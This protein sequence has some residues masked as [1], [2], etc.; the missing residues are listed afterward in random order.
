MEM[1][2][3]ITYEPTSSFL[4]SIFPKSVQLLFAC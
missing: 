3:H 2:K 1:E 4:Y